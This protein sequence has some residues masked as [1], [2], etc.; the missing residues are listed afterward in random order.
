MAAYFGAA[1]LAVAIG[2]NGK[3][4]GNAKGEKEAQ[5]VPVAYPVQRSVTDYVD[6]TGRTD[7]VQSVSVRARA[8]GNIISIPFA[9]GAEVHGPSGGKP[10]DL[11]FEID[12]APYQAAVELAQ[13]QLEVAKA[14][15]VL[16]KATYEQDKSAAQAVSKQQLNQDK[17]AVDVAAARI[18]GAEATLKQ[19]ELNLS[20][21][22]VRAPITGEV[23][24]YFL[25]VGNLVVQDATLLTTIV[26]MD[27]MYA[28]FDMDERTL[29]RYKR[30]IL[31]GTIKMP[32]SKMNVSDQDKSEKDKLNEAEIN[33]MM[34]LEGEDLEGPGAYP[35]RGRINFINNQVNPATGTMMV[36][37]IFRNERPRPNAPWPLVPGMFVRIHLPLGEPHPSLLV[38][39]RAIGSDQG[40][41]FVYVVDDDNKVQYRPVITGALE[42]DGLRVIEK[43]DEEKQ[44]GLKPTDLVVVGALQQ[45][46]PH[47]VV[48][49]EVQTEMPKMSYGETRRP[50]APPHTENAKKK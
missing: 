17:A 25:T 19:A 47:T 21:T 35:H 2:C 24:R 42:N 34:A 44:T 40:S 14:Q 1:L 41:K 45:L 9:E 18:V 12:P 16:A 3:S 33:V 20:Y 48:K 10:G 5:V 22:K 32:Q 36:R 30:G 31:N 8:Q 29:N 50:Q 23:S 27:P 43:W 11:L 15:L 6:Y 39:D 38:I 28:Y 4:P 26:S 7:A 46:R 37:G 49:K 13:S